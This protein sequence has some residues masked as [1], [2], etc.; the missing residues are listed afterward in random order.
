MPEVA[1]GF[2]RSY[3]H[4]APGNGRIV[5]VRDFALMD[6]TRVHVVGNEKELAENNVNM[7]GPWL[8]VNVMK[9]IVF[10]DIEVDAHA[11]LTALQNG[12]CVRRVLPNT[13]PAVFVSPDPWTH[14]STPRRRMY[15]LNVVHL[16]C[17]WEHHGITVNLDDR[18]N[19]EEPIYRKNV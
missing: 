9:P 19:I 4:I 2:Y 18:F 5:L 12:C 7:L 16:D 6:G 11:A 8:Q 1:H 17:I 3:T 15:R 10:R 14:D 13:Y